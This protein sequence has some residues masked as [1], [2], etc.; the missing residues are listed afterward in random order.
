MLNRR[1]YSLKSLICS[2]L[3]LSS[4]PAWGTDATGFVREEGCDL[5]SANHLHLERFDDRATQKTIILNL[6]S[7]L[8]YVPKDWFDVPGMECTG[9]QQCVPAAYAKI[10]VL[11]LSHLWWGK[12]TRRHEMSGKYAVKINDGTVLEGSFQAKFRKSSKELI[13][14]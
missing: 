12:W 10:Q 1:S 11:R 6:P 13:C 3:L 2:L 7:P 4:L 8:E 14:E 9:P 5:M